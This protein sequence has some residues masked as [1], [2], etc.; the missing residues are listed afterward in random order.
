M[1]EIPFRLT[2]EETMLLHA[3]R[4]KSAIE[5]TPE[6]RAMILTRRQ[7]ALEVAAATAPTEPSLEEIRV[8]MPETRLREILAHVSRLAR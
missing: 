7:K 3:I 2:D 1:F 4:A 8:G 5:P 6:E